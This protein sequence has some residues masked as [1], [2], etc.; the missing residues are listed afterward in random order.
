MR[1]MLTRDEFQAVY[2]QGAD[3]TYGLLQQMQR[4]IDALSVQ[5]AQLSERIKQLE[6]RLAQDSHN[7]SKPPSSDGLSKPTPNPRSL[8]QQTGRPSGG[9]PGHPGRT[10][11]M[12]EHPDVLVVHR[13]PVCAACGGSLEGADIQIQPV[14]P[15]QRRQVF[16]LPPQ[17]LQVT[18][19]QV[20]VCLCPNP[21]CQ[22]LNQA[23]FPAEVTQ[24]AQYGPGVLGLGVYLTQYQLLPLDRA[25]QLLADVFGRGPCQ[26]T[27]QTAIER[28]ELVL[29]PVEDAIKQAVVDAPVVHFD[30]TGVRVDKCLEWLH[31][32]STGLLTFYACH[33]KRGREAFADIDVLPRVKGVAEHDAFHSYMAP[34]YPCK[35]SL[36]NAHLLRELLGLWENHHQTWTQRLSALLRSLYA[37]K[38]RAQEA[39]LSAL[40]PERLQRY[41][42]TYRRIVERALE[43]NPR[44]EPTGQKGRPV[45]GPVRNMLERLDTHE[46]AVLRF[47][48][49]FAVPF[50]NNQAERDVRMLKVH[51]KVSGC[52]RTREGVERFCRIR[53]YISTLRKQGIDVRA[54]LCSVLRRQ[55]FMPALHPT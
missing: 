2:D 47:A 1:V 18:E 52:F 48:Y 15:L 38:C 35:H 32:A 24:P 55:P 33:A 13:P 26:G 14:Q 3:A 6:A 49:E 40:A 39:E 29:R 43:R 50:D 4:T 17:R 11:Q 44:P 22:A 16:D 5:V 51:E 31:V 30:E 25:E 53:G 21:H 7:S 9:Q 8:R 45:R 41:R 23:D 42:Q 20:P 12:A 10:L 19:H 27:L 28:C 37:D 36:C 54:G 46:E 34:S